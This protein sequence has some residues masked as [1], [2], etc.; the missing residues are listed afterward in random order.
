MTGTATK[1]NIYDNLLVVLITS[2]VFGYAGGA[3]LSPVNFVELLF[4]PYLLSNRNLL[5][6]RV[7]ARLL[8]F[9][10]LWLSYS[11]LSLV[12]ASNVNRGILTI[13]IYFFR[14]LMCLEMLVFSMRANRPL[15]SISK[16]WF[17]AVILTAVVALWEIFTNHHLSIAREESLSTLSQEVQ[18]AEASV[19]FYN[20]NTYCVFLVMAFPFLAY[21][22]LSEKKK[23][24][25]IT[26]LLVLFF[27]VV[28]NASRGAIL[29]VGIMTLMLLLF[30]V[31]NK[32]FRGY[33]F[34]LLALLAVFFVLFGESLFSAFLFRMETQGMQDGARLEIWDGAW[35]TF[36]KSRGF[37]VGVGS[38]TK[39]LGALNSYGI[40]YAHCLL[41]ESLVEGGVILTALVLFVLFR[42]LKLTVSVHQKTVRIVLWMALITFP[43]YS[44]INSEY[45]RPAFVWSFFM[46]AFLYALHKESDP[47]KPAL[48]NR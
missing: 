21:K 8:L 24:L 45:L 32:R 26:V 30:F 12:W 10:I 22:L 40:E 1:T 37:G 15:E 34:V 23:A 38:M 29:S 16:G 27:I 11:V 31:K 47:Q 19:L 28:K 36:L 4:F 17:L 18:R 44:I 48:K 13:F 46:S 35:S 9:A 5:R 25:T 20:P 2:L 14:F 43:V 42:L 7:S 33:G 3:V 41:L 39:H 6:K